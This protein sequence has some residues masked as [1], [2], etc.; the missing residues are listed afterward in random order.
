MHPSEIITFKLTPSLK[1]PPPDNL[2]LNFRDARHAIHRFS[3]GP[4][5]PILGLVPKVTPQYRYAGHRRDQV[6]SPD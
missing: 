3:P 1:K 2:Q 5:Q 4:Q 6:R